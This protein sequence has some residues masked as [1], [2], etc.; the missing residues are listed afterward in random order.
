[1]TAPAGIPCAALDL[2]VGSV[3][4]HDVLATMPEEWGWEHF[5]AFRRAVEGMLRP[6][7]EVSFH[8]S[9]LTFHFSRFTPCTGAT[10]SASSSPA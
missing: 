10:S 5:P 4:I 1:M 8:V 6:V 7:A 9:L 3:D 2:R